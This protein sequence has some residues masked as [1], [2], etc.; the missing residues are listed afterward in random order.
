M[1]FKKIPLVMVMLLLSVFAV[2][3]NRSEEEATNEEETPTE[4]TT[5]TTPPDSPSAN[6]D[7]QQTPTAGTQPFQ[8]RPTVTGTATFIPPTSPQQR[9]QQIATGRPDPYAPFPSKVDVAR[10]EETAVNG[11]AP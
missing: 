5:E 8:P 1:M 3:C 11:T 10:P 4:T 2:S 6:V 9:R 7:N